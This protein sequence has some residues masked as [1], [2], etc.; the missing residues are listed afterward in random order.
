MPFNLNI[1]SKN[2][3]KI[4]YIYLQNKKQNLIEIKNK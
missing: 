4:F 2:I 3:F 1:S